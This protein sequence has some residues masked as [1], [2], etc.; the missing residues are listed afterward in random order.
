VAVV[1]RGS[2]FPTKVPHFTRAQFEF[3]ALIIS[4]YHVLMCIDV[5]TCSCHRKQVDIA[6]HFDL[7]LWRTNENYNDKAFLKMA[8]D[9]DI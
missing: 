7:Y 5:E 9:I 2:T 1:K 8:A 4:R 6:E 3:I